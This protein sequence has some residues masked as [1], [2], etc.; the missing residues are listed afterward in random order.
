M[1]YELG[2]QEWMKRRNKYQE[3]RSIRTVHLI[4]LVARMKKEKCGIL[5]DK[6]ALNQE[7]HTE[8]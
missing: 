5:T 8:I 4:D 3:F 6:K 2:P 1:I 7:L